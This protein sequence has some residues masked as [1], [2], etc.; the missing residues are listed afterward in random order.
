MGIT[1]QLLA[2]RVQLATGH[3]QYGCG[4]GSSNRPSCKRVL[5][6]KHI[7]ASNHEHRCV[8]LP[9]ADGSLVLTASADGT[10][11]AFEMERGQCLRVLA[12]ALVA[13]H[14]FFIFM[15]RCLL[16]SARLAA[17][18]TSP[19]AVAAGVQLATHPGNQPSGLA[20]L[21]PLVCRAANPAC[22]LLASPCAR[23]SGGGGAVGLQVKH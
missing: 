4:V 22:T 1:L 20:L 8:C 15:W 13:Q 14:L 19:P 18:C 12:G 2:A 11:R 6:L 5:K 21:W 9:S 17:T 16:W 23:G 7:V 3:G 10:A